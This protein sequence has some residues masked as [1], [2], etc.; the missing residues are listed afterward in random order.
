[1]TKE[2]FKRRENS[3]EEWY[4]KEK[5]KLNA[6]RDK[7]DEMY[8]EKI[9]HLNGLALEQMTKNVKP[10]DICKDCNNVKGCIT[11]TNGD[12]YCHITEIKTDN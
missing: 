4:V 9:K 8:K 2:Q 1:M 5:A 7:L 6:K 10:V 11:C 12:Q 3:I